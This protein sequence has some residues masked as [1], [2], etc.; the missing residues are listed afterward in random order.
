MNFAG[1]QIQG[2]RELQEDAYTWLQ[3]GDAQ[4]AIVADGLGGHL[5]GDFASR[6]AVTA[7]MEYFIA[8]RGREI[9]RPPQEL[10]RE[11]FGAAHA[12]LLQRGDEG[13]SLRNMGTTL[14][15]LLV[16]RDRYY[17]GV[18]GD[19]PIYL[20]RADQLTRF[21]WPRSY[22]DYGAAALM[23]DRELRVELG[24]SE[25]EDLKPGDRFLV[26]SDGI[27]TLSDDRIAEILR[28]AASPQACV[29]DLLGETQR[30]VLPSDWM[31]HSQK[32]DNATVIVVFP[33]EGQS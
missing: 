19:S 1:G 21:D 22:R 13:Y 20:L 32:Q 5:Y 26:A 7:C 17:Y 8:Q 18:A 27:N 15:V 10:L 9:E 2:A 11:A 31:A 25:G 28:T 12:A 14:S 29:G 30:T 16:Q 24:F 6:I 23:A 33:E 4:I 3:E